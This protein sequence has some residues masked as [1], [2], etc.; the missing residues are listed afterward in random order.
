MRQGDQNDLFPERVF[1]RVDST[2]NKIASIVEW[3]DGHA[4]RQA[5]GNLA[6]FL[7]DADNNFERVLAGAHY[8]NS[9]NHLAPVHVECAT[10]EISTN[11]Y[12]GNIAQVDGRPL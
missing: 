6:D 3:L 1:E 4:R 10:P 8:H 11:L 7:F 9:S 5:V 2:V 12:R